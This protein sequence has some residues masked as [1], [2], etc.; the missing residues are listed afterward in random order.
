[1]P[2]ETNIPY[3]SFSVCH[4]LCVLLRRYCV[5]DFISVSVSVPSVAETGRGIEPF[6]SRNFS[7]S[8]PAA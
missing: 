1:M 7:C 6:L 3:L 4:G 8:Y 2:E 5:F